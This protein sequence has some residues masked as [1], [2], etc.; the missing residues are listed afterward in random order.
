MV[1]EFEV[2]DAVAF[3]LKKLLPVIVVFEDRVTFPDTVTEVSKVSVPVQLVELN[4][5]HT[6]SVVET[7]QEF[8]LPESN[9]TLSAA[10]GMA[11]AEAPV[12]LVVLQEV[13]LFQAVPTF[14]K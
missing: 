7:G 6:P 13:L 1:T 3:I 10:V 9:I 5:K 8:A 12:L 11:P 14:L 2:I 4:V